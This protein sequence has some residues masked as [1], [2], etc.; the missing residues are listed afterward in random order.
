MYY[1]KNFLKKNNKNNITHKNQTLKTFL[2]IEEEDEFPYVAV[3]AGGGACLCLLLLGGGAFIFFIAF[4]QKQN[5]DVKA[6][7]E[8]DP[9]GGGARSNSQRRL[10]RTASRSGGVKRTSSRHLNTK[11]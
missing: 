4:Y 6:A 5:R 11:W 1:K 9:Y 7:R 8:L 3:G 2:A 10:S